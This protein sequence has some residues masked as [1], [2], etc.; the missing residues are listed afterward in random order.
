MHVVESV[1][2]GVF[3]DAD[4]VHR[5]EYEGEQTRLAALFQSGLELDIEGSYCTRC[6]HECTLCWSLMLFEQCLV[7]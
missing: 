3:H 6:V 7:Y 1:R 5:D 2:R 4:I